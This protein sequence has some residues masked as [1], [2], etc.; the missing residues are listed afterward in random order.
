MPW[1]HTYESKYNYTD[2]ELMKKELIVE[3]VSV[4]DRN[5]MFF[6]RPVW[7]KV[8]KQTGRL[9][10]AVKRLFIRYQDVC[11][12]VNEALEDLRNFMEET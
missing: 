7:Y 10:N 8:R 4:A 5:K 12:F 9:L 2:G 3:S 11:V 1:S 6:D